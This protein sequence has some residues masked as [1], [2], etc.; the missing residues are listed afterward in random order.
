MHGVIPG[1][2][3]VESPDPLNTA[4]I[5]HGQA[6]PDQPGLC[7]SKPVLEMWLPATRMRMTSRS[8]LVFMASGSGLLPAPD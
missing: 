7:G 8:G 4:S 2:R 5:R 1:L 3:E 6:C